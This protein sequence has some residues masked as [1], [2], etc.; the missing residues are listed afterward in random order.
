MTNDEYL[1]FFIYGVQCNK[2]NVILYHLQ[3]ECMKG[4]KKKI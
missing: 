2:W 4:F 3:S 1:Q